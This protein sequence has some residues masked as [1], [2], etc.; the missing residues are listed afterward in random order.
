MLMSHIA[1]MND[2]EILS[3]HLKFT[4]YDLDIT[5]NLVDFKFDCSETIVFYVAQAT[6][7][8]ILNGK[9]LTVD[10]VRVVYDGEVYI[11]S[12]RYEK[13]TIHFEFEHELE[14][15]IG[16]N[17]TIAIKFRGTLNDHL[18]GFYKTRYVLPDGTEKFAGTTQFE[19]HDA[20]RAFVCADEPG[21]KATYALTLN[22][23]KPLIALSNTPVASSTECIWDNTLKTVRFRSTP[24]MSSYLVAW[25]VGELEY[26]ETTC[27][28]PLSGK[29]TTVRTYTT[30]GKKEQAEYAN[31]YAAKVLEY[32]ADY[33]DI[34]YPLPKMDQIAVP[35]FAAG[36]MENWGLVT[37]REQLI[38]QN[39]STSD[40]MK[41]QIAAT[42]AHELAHQ[43]FGNLVTPE[44][45]NDLWLKEGFA[46][47]IGWMAVNHFNPEWK[48][49]QYFTVE[50]YQRALAL[51]ELDS[52]HPINNNVKKVEEVDEIFD[53]ISYL[54]GASMLRMLAS[55]LG[56]SDFKM[57]MRTY[58]KKFQYQNAVT[59]DL[60]EHLSI[61][62]NKN[63]AETMDSWI[64]QQ[65]YP[66]VT[67]SKNRFNQYLFS[68]QPYGGERTDRRKW[69]IPLNLSWKVKDDVLFDTVLED[70]WTMVGIENNQQLVK[71]NMG[72]SGFFRTQYDPSMDFY[73]K[74]CIKSCK[75]ETLDRSEIF[76]TMFDLGK[77][78]YDDTLRALEFLEYYEN[79]PDFLVWYE[80]IS[81]L[82][83]LKFV[84][85][86][87]P[88]VRES[89]NTFLTR[90]LKPQ[91]Q[92]LGWDFKV[93]DTYQ[94]M[95]M[96]QL[97][98]STLAGIG[99]ETVLNTCRKCFD[100]FIRDP[101]S[102]DN[103]ALNPNI[104]LSVFVSVV[105]HSG[106]AGKELQQLRDAFSQV[107]SLEIRC[108]ILEALGSTKDPEELKKSFDFSFKSG[109]VRLQDMD[110]VLYNIDKS[111]TMNAWEYITKNW[112][113]ILE[114]FGTN[115]VGG[116]LI[117]W[118]VCAP[119]SNM[120][121]PEE[122][123]QV[124]DFLEKH[125]KDVQSIQN[126]IRQVTERCEKLYEWYA[127]DKDAVISWAMSRNSFY[128][129]VQSPEPSSQAEDIAGIVT[130]L[131]N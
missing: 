27:K 119:L 70:S 108:E 71:V 127:R 57:G 99:E 118:L 29:E 126:G 11:P 19:S 113:N 9:H 88:V 124:A 37:Y 63:V 117:H 97:V 123:H 35:D 121:L 106:G 94:T 13:E 102:P 3:Q 89:I 59:E 46:T 25:Y 77:R 111:L 75:L 91:L 60:W 36:A 104:R 101:S 96:R 12:V 65:G 72:R 52:S 64:N 109:L 114:T 100:D 17:G 56:E 14:P 82:N 6:K 34:D 28:Q 20:R 55:W 90:V 2:R 74:E 38:L 7:E 15:I 22:V 87:H 5:P 42:I 69:K 112:D 120:I 122:R 125:E 21:K 67:V 93:E 103:S 61:S 78:G 83:N 68:Q 115:G 73:L 10:H 47:Y 128:Q 53:T 79:E 58:L 32:F 33:F 76:A 8:I 43:W 50:C 49:W 116:G 107:A 41:M 66:L 18:C 129:Q 98:I 26:V 40:F 39:E 4:H 62:S 105:R 131:D 51:D 45:W 92:T 130:E 16:M 24:V 54:K 84:W 48:C 81:R 110:Y 23:P 31:E 85:K 1:E 86:D 30:P 80:I 44:W 95:K